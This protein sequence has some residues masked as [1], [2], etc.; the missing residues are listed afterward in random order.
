MSDELDELFG[1]GLD[2]EGQHIEK[3]R[4][5]GVAYVPNKH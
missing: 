5:D 2:L 1:G 3:G 4:V